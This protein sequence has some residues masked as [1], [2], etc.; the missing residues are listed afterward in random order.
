MGTK[1]PFSGH[2]SSQS[3]TPSFGGSRAP[4]EPILATIEAFDLE[5]LARFNAVLLSDLGG[6][7]DLPL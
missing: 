5:F 4:Y 2:A 6:Q 7:H 1:N 3:T